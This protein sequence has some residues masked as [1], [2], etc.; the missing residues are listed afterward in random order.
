MST[1]VN[2]KEL[3]INSIKILSDLISFKTVSGEDNSALINYCEEYLHKLEQKLKY[4][5]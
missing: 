4:M 2:L 5:L 1:E 3:Y